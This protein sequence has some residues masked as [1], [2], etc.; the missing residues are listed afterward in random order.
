MSTQLMTEPW[1]EYLVEM[2][3]PLGRTYQV[4]VLAPPAPTD[5]CP[6]LFLTDADIAFGAARD[7]IRMAAWGGEIPPTILVGVGYGAQTLGE[8]A[9][10]REWDFTTEAPPEDRREIDHQILSSQGGAEAFFDFLTGPVADLVQARYACDPA[11]FGLAGY[12]LGGAFA[13]WAMLHRPDAFRAYAIG[14]AAS[15]RNSARVL[16]ALLAADLSATLIE[17]VYISAGELE[18][19]AEQADEKRFVGNFLVAARHLRQVL[20]QR[21]VLRAEIIPGETHFGGSLAFLRRG[22]THVLSSG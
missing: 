6:T 16:R 12:S 21:C 19:Y 18:D 15:Y 4:R 14:S 3:G 10:R 5:G 9:E 20:P 7:L 13:L 8:F 22:L 1:D 11:R 2:V 17:R